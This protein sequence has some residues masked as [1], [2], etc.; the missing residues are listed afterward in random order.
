M[1]ILLLLL[2]SPLIRPTRNATSPKAATFS[3]TNESAGGNIS[4]S[5]ASG[6]RVTEQT[7]QTVSM[8]IYNPTGVSPGNTGFRVRSLVARVPTGMQLVMNDGTVYDDNTLLIR[9]INLMTNQQPSNLRILNSDAHLDEILGANGQNIVV[10][11]SYRGISFTN[12]TLIL[13]LVL[14]L[15]QIM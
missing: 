15:V 14:L 3:G 12:R 5:I 10:S 4:V 2:H 7:G 9:D 13:V 11:G 8:A 6:S 1:L